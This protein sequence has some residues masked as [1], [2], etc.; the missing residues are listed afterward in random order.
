MTPNVYLKCTV[1]GKHGGETIKTLLDTGNTLR[2][3]SAINADLHRRL[4]VGFANRR[5]GKCGTAKAGTSLA[6][7][8]VSNPIILKLPGMK[9]RITI[10]PSVV[11]QLSDQLNLGVGLLT[12]LGMNTKT[13]VSFEKG[14]TTLRIGAE[15]TGLIQEIKAEPERGR[16][17]ER[18]MGTPRDREGSRPERPGLAIC[19]VTTRCKANSLTFAKMTLP[20]EYHSKTVLVE[21]EERDGLEVV[22]AVYKG[23]GGINR[24]AILNTGPK[25]LI[26]HPGT[27]LGKLEVQKVHKRTIQEQESLRRLERAEREAGPARGEDTPEIAAHKAQILKDLKID[28]NPMLQKN[29]EIRGRLEEMINRYW[30]VFGEPDMSTGLTDLAEFKI[31]LKEGACPQRAQVRP[32]NPLRMESLRNQMKI[33]QDEGVI[34]EAESPWASALVPAKKKGGLIRWA[35]DY[36]KLNEVTVADSYP[37]PSIEMNLERLAGSKVFSALDA[38]A[39]YNVI[40]VAKESRPLL[41]FITPMGLFTYKRMPF[42]PKNS[43]AV[44]ARFIEGLLDG[45][46]SDRVIAYLDDVLCF[47]KTMDEHLE[48]LDRVLFMHERAGI[49][50]RPLKTKLFEERTEYLG[51]E[52]SQEGVAMQKGYIDRIMDWPVPTTVKELATFLGFVGYYRAFIREFSEL[53]HEMNAQRKEK[54]LKWTETMQ[55]DFEILKKKFEERPIR[56]YPRYDLP[57]EFQ[58]TTDFSAKAIGGVL[59]QEQ[60]GQERLLGCAARKCTPYEQNYPSVKGELAALMYC[61]RKWEHLLRYRKF[62]VNTDSQALKYL[63][64]LKCPTGIWFRWLEELSSYDFEVRHRPGKENVNA[65]ALSRSDHH[66]E[67]T[68]EEVAEQEREFGPQLLRAIQELEEGEQEREIKREAPG[69]QMMH[70]V[71]EELSREALEET[72]RGDEILGQVRTWVERG[73]RPDKATLRRGDDDLRIYHQLFESLQMRD[74]LLYFKVR[75]NSQAGEEVWRVVL[76]R[77]KAGIAFEWAHKHPTA[78]HFGVTA[79]NRRATSRFYYPG[80]TLDLKR[81]VRSCDRCIAKQT[82][83]DTHA[84]VHRPVA[85]GAIGQEVFIDLIGPLPVT[86]ENLKY[87]LTVEDGFTR[88]VSIYPLPNKSAPTVARALVEKYFTVHGIPAVVKSDNGREFVNAIMQEVSDRLQLTLKTSPVYNPHSNQVERFHRTLNQMMRVFEQR[89]DVN[90]PLA[91]PCIMMAYNTKVHQTTGV[92]PYFATFGREMRLP[93]DLVVK[94]PEPEGRAMSQVVDETTA[95]F[96]KIYQFMRNNQEAAIRRAASAYKNKILNLKAGDLVWYLCPRQVP[97]KPR[98]LTDSWLGPYRVVGKANDVVW[99]I[100]PHTYDGPAIMVH[101]QR[102][103]PCTD[104]EAKN[105]IPIRLQL[106]DEGDE[107][108]EEIRPPGREGDDARDELGIPVALQAPLADMA[109]LM[110]PSWG[111]GAPASPGGD[112]EGT[113]DVPEMNADNNDPIDPGHGIPDNNNLQNAEYETPH[114]SEDEGHDNLQNAEYGAPHVPDLLDPDISGSQ[115]SGDELMGH[116]SD[117]QAIEEQIEPHPDPPEVEDDIM[118]DGEELPPLPE[119]PTRISKRRRAEPAEGEERPSRRQRVPVTVPPTPPGVRTR[120]PPTKGQIRVEVP[121]TPPKV[122][123]QQRKKRVLS[124]DGSESEPIASGSGTKP[125]GRA[126]TKKTKPRTAWQQAVRGGPLSSDD[127]LMEHISS[128]KEVEILIDKDSDEPKRGTPGSAAWDLW[129]AAP[130]TIP[131]GGT[132]K[133]PLKLKLAIPEGYWLLLLGRSGLASKGITVQG[134]VIDGDFREEIKCLLSNQ[135]GETFKVQ[136]GQRVCQAVLLPRLDAKFT[137]VDTL[138][139]PETSHQGFGS[140]GSF[141]RDAGVDAGDMEFSH[142]EPDDSGRPPD[143]L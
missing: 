127:E 26:I 31:K 128:L 86:P 126:N 59:S 17:Q 8:G 5:L 130:V 68:P 98:K 84:G 112:P 132:A 74:G 37:L 94:P 95:R 78:G 41:A 97:G 124:P 82:R 77:E 49:K 69:M 121:P 51:F 55:R 125:K 76:P 87:A 120:I 73:R 100:K 104:P 57:D 85:T 39:A 44:Y 138:P 47:T 45:L 32:L 19:A 64:N 91:L 9:T 71:G 81:M 131:Q 25:D 43:G 36:R 117:P 137:R 38:A 102:L 114:V 123:E 90:W 12:R 142:T 42:G 108:G 72:Q 63:R 30:R 67:P 118:G 11:E 107:L 35:I 136:R 140:T 113:P 10:R 60:G 79:T 70:R 75:M 4:G 23:Q 7:L 52:V 80:M 20:P 58:L 15:E 93:I 109:D 14:K 2:E 3:E 18:D 29:P 65:D 92:T 83:I 89:E 133:V 34:E 110:P 99:K 122:R 103:L 46:K 115:G 24:I 33:W 13:T 101:E 54:E 119:T 1:T 16:G 21:H 66:P 56:S 40:P 105:R 50:L 141:E 27:R 143:S 48:V 96:R 22:G 106:D 134:G 116:E 111:D 61:C 88:H 135:S 53:T 62:I 6:K 28:E 139:E 129:A